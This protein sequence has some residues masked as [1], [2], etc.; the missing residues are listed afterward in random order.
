MLL[1]EGG[2]EDV[3]GNEAVTEE[4]EKD[5]ESQQTML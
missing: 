2:R 5:G 1:V 3:E 4:I